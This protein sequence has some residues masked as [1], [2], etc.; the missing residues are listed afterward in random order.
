MAVNYQNHIH[1]DTAISGS[2]EFAPVL[3][4]SVR[5]PGRMDSPEVVMSLKRARNGKLHNHVLSSAGAPIQF[6]NYRYIVV[7]RARDGDTLL[8]RINKLKALN[9]KEVTMVDNFH[10]DNG[11]SHATYGLQYICQVG[12]FRN[13]DQ[14]VPEWFEVEVTLTDAGTV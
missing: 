4:W 8:Q 2:P 14:P 7:V 12:E 1:L 6:Q 11:E 13:T 3:K 10:P 9:G 5:F